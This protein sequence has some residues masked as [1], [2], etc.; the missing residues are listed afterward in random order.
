LGTTPKLLSNE[1]PDAAFAKLAG[2]D[3]DWTKKLKARNKAERARGKNQLL[4]GIGSAIGTTE[5]AERARELDERKLTT[6]DDYRARAGAWRRFDRDDADL[7]A[8]RFAADAWCAAFV[9]P[10]RPSD[11]PGITHATV[12][13]ILDGDPEIPQSVDLTVREQARTFQFFHWHLEF[14]TIFTVPEPGSGDD[15]VDPAT[16]WRGGFSCVIGNPPWERLKIQDKEFFTAKGADKIANAQTAAIRKAMIER[17]EHEAPDL[18]RNYYV[19]QRQSEA[20]ANLVRAGGRFPFTASGDV[21]T[22]SVFAETFRTITAPDGAAGIITPTGLATDKT[23]SRFFGDALSAKRVLAFYDFENEAKVFPGVHHSVRFAITTMS[24]T[25]R[26][27]VETRFAFLNRHL[28]DIAEKRFELAPH[29]VMAMNPNTGNLPMFRTRTDADITLRVYRRFPV[30]VL[31]GAPHGDPWKLAFGTMF[32]MAN[33]SSLF[34]GTDDLTSAAFD[35]WSYSFGARQLLPLYEAKMLGHFDHRFSTYRNATQAQLN[36][37]ALPRPST[38][39]HDDPGMESLARYWVNNSA[40]RAELAARWDRGW[41]LGWRDIARSIDMRTF[42]P[43][44]LP[45]SAVGDAFLLA[46]P[47]DPAHG[48]LLHAAWSSLVFDYV[49]RQKL[50][51]T[52]MKFFVTKQLACPIPDTFHRPVSWQPDRSLAQWVRP[53][54]LELSYTSW[55]LLPYANEMHDDGPP[56]RWDPERRARLR[57]DLDAAFLHVYGLARAEAEHVLDSFFVVRKYDERD[58]GEFRTKRLVLDAYDRMAIAADR[59]GAGWE[60]LAGTSAGEG[61]RHP[62]DPA[63][64]ALARGPE[65]LSPQTMRS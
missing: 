25:D 44:V 42:V 6:L 12:A 61:P 38:E 53:Y 52:H 64:R 11:I 21:N 15:D 50:S 16:G 48:P 35:G 33:D 54:V 20:M 3:A 8:R 62:D 23:T 22:Y 60:P 34:A 30:L 17:L 4:L 37:G 55:R 26:V 24:G 45:T 29:E 2:D 41:L 39:Q 63:G 5:L 28:T 18:Y 36:V 56:F 27:A 1:L 9:Q 49:A 58:F 10:K 65:S 59:G 40:T 14:P 46:F 31:D 7:Q 51:G 57:A 47:E 43:S 32:H 13:R 19:A